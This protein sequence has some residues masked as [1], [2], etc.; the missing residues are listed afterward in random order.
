[1][2][3]VSRAPSCSRTTKP[4][5]PGYTSSPAFK[6]IGLATLKWVATS[7]ALLRRAWRLHM[8]AIV[9]QSPAGLEAGALTVFG[10][11]YFA[12]VARQAS[13]Q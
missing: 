4:G 10:L 6:E 5:A 9:A 11:S 8:E 7:A 3:C 2:L 1:M 12:D 13:R